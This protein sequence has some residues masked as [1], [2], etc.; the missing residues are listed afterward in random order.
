M[1]KTKPIIAITLGDPAGI[2]PEVAI[3]VL[4]K[5]VIYD[6]CRPLLIGDVRVLEQ[7]VNFVDVKVAFHVVSDVAEADFR[8]GTID[9]FDLEN[10]APNQFEV[11]QVSARA[12]AAAFEYV[13]T[14]IELAIGE[15]VDGT[16]TN[17]INKE[18]LNLAGHHYSGHTEIYAEFTDTRDFSMLLVGGNLRVAHVTTHVPLSKVSSLIKRDRILKVIQLV[19]DA[20]IQF[21]IDRPKIG[22]AGLNP[23]SGDGGLFGNEEAAEIAP[24]INAAREQGLDVDGPIAPDTIF[25]KANAGVYDGCVAMYHDQGHIPF[26]MAS[27]IWSSQKQAVE[28]I[29]GVNVTLGLPIIRTSVDHGTAFDIAGKGIASSDA[30]SDAIKIAVTMAKIRM[31]RKARR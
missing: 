16:V 18:S 14:A 20:C 1:A 10:I 11:G 28:S 2:G 21:G 3:K 24:A 12:G 23:H 7:A 5:P 15:K 31:Q 13:K 8:P 29:S 27:F 6:M 4:A 30:L 17:P 19:S 22:V 26:K 9:V 25:A